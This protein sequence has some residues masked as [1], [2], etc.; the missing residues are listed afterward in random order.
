MT[1]DDNVNYD[2]LRRELDKRAPKVI[3][4]RKAEMDKI[5]KAATKSNV[6]LT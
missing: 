2:L 5:I 1:R 6:V 3:K 4:V